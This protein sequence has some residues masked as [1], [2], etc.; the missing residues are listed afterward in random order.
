MCFSI[1]GAIYYFVTQN[2]TSNINLVQIVKQEDDFERNAFRLLLSQA[3]MTEF[4]QK[5]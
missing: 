2:L 5:K 1:L 4:D 3:I